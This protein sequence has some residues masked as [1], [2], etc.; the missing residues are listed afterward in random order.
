M[1]EILTLSHIRWMIRRDYPEVLGIDRAGHPPAWSEENLACVLRERN[2]IGM[3]AE[4]YAGVVGFMVYELRPTSLA[5][6]KL[7]V[8]PDYRLR[9]VGSQMIDQ[10]VHKLT[11]HYRTHITVLV[12]ETNLPAQ[13]FFRDRGFLAMRVLRSHFKDS[14][15]DAYLMKLEMS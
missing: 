13:L 8:H 11:T 12:R 14:G 5:I 2:C 1:S 4:R 3:V 10:L 15:E 6:L 7:G 9:G